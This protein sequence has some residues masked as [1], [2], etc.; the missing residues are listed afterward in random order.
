MTDITYKI[1][2]FMKRKPGMSME[3]FRDYYE[4][5]H[6]PLCRKYMAG[7]VRY[8]R[9]YLEPQPNA[10]TGRNDELPYDVVTEMWFDDEATYRRTL[11]YITTNVMSDEVIADESNFFD[12]ARNRIATVIECETDMSA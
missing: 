6:V 7:I 4:N 11:E 12:R 10:E 8:M 1:L 9:R 2:L 3:D 5:R